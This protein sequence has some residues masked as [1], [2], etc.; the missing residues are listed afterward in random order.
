MSDLA[1]LEFPRN[2]IYACTTAEIP[3]IFQGIGKQQ[4]VVYVKAMYSNPDFSD[5]VIKPTQRTTVVILKRFVE[6][7][8]Y[9]DDQKFK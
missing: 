3:N 6:Y 1:D 9:M 4:A 2:K 8:K 5:G 7:L